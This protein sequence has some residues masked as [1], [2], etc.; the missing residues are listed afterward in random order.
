MNIGKVISERRKLL[1]FTQ[2]SLSQ[3]LNV[4]AQAISKWENGTSYPDVTLLP[5]LA[6]I[7]SISIDS[8]LGY[9]SQSV[10]Y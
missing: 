3:R 8:L 1:G 2:Q 9:P 5:Q 4:S 7:L 10:T 6:A